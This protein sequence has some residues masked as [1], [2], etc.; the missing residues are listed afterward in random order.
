MKF[1]TSCCRLVSSRMPSSC[2][3]P[4]YSTL[5]DQSTKSEWP[6][7][8]SILGRS[9]QANGLGGLP[10]LADRAQEQALI[11]GVGD[12]LEVR[13]LGLGNSRDPRAVALVEKLGYSLRAE[14]RTGLDRDGRLRVRR[15]RRIAYR[16]VDLRRQR[17][18]CR[19]HRL[20]RRTHRIRIV[21]VQIRLARRSELVARAAELAQ[22]A[23][24][25][26]SEL[27]QLA[28]PEEQQGQYPDDEHILQADIEHPG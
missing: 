3:R 23:T 21:D 18:R 4:Y 13:A 27:G 12:V 6:V 25:H 17:G 14:R 28:G 22:G 9:R 2:S 7:L 16:R 10:G 19:L 26:A 24:D 8:S 20:R 1:S 15:H 5:V 11:A